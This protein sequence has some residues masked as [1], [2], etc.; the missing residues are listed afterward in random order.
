MIVD[1]QPPTLRLV[2]LD[3]TSRVRDANLTIENDRP[4]CRS[5]GG[6]RTADYCPS[7]PMGVL[8]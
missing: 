7:M 2:N 6:R 4:G 8:A 5:S 1:T 3:E